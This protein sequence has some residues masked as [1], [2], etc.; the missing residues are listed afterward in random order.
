MELKETDL[1]SISRDSATCRTTVTVDMGYDEKGRMLKVRWLIA[2]QGQL[3]P[4]DSS[5]SIRRWLLT[6]Y[7]DNATDFEHDS[8]YAFRLP[9]VAVELKAVWWHTLHI[10]ALV[11][12]YDPEDF[13]VPLPGYN[14]L[15]HPD[16]EP[17][18][19]EQCRGKQAHLI[20]PEGLYVPPLEMELFNLVAGRPVE[21][22]IGL[23]REEE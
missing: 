4:I 8:A 23:A 2:G 22:T 16:T 1:R 10:D 3:Q 11:Q 20:V 17:C 15:E 13:H 21:V 18:Q 7:L 14:P 5:L 12:P 9:L 19:A 6:S